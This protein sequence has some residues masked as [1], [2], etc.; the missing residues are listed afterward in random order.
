MRLRVASRAFRWRAGLA[1]ALS[2]AIAVGSPHVPGP[3]AA[4]QSEPTLTLTDEAFW[5]LVTDMSEPDGTFRS[6]NLVSNEVAYQHV[7]PAMRRVAP[8][9][10][11]IGVGPDQNFTYIGTL[12]PA[13]A[14]IVDVRRGNL[15]LHL[16]YKA[17]FE[18]SPTRTEFV[19]RLFGRHAP[20]PA[21][22]APDRWLDAVAREAPEGRLVAAARAAIVDRLVRARGFPL[23]A[24]DRAAIGMLHQAFVRYGPGV[25][26]GT[27]AGELDRGAPSFADLQGASDLSGLE[28][29][30]LA[31]D[32]VY[33]A[34]RARHLA[35]AIVPV[36]GDFGGPH[37]L[38]A[39]SAW[40]EAHGMVLSVFYASNVE[41]YLFGDGRWPAF[42]DSLGAMPRGEDSLLI[43][44]TSGSSRLDPILG[45]LAD[46]RSGKI[47]TYADITGRVGIR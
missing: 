23:S 12:E 32:D 16:L 45:L 25:T 35:N 30:Y 8:R 41:E 40:L 7:I 17:L 14:F 3:A 22:A 24:A 37:A 31:S 5:S 36:V 15:R 27:S 44:S 47:R 33:A 34:V 1:L 28:H 19:E 26:Y 46:V 20:E 39:V 10:A 13:V 2:A 42:Y 4:R 21:D 38:A 43:R 18:V 11:Y 6:D 29:G 9:G